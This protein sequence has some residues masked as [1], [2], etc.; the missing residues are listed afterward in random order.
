MSAVHSP[1][2]AC[3][4]ETVPRHTILHA[5]GQRLRRSFLDQNDHYLRTPRLPLCTAGEA[6]LGSL[7]RCT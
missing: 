6:L 2:E 4:K 7:L 5:S 1:T 3:G